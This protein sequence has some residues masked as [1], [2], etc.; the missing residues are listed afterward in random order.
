MPTYVAFLR[1]INLGA[2]RRFPKA[3]VLAATG[4]AGGEDVQAYLNTGNVLLTS[5][6]RSAAAVARDLER[7]YAEDRGF[8]VPTIVFTTAEVAAI[9][10]T[11]D[12]LV[13]ELGE[14]AQLNVT[15]Y[16]DPPPA[17]AARAVE[18]L[19]LPDR[20]VVRDRA[21][22]VFLHD[23]FHGSKLLG[24]KEFRA[25]GA[26]TARNVTVLREIARRWCR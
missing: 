3:D 11:A 7:A 15:L 22:Y 6:R 5:R 23:G 18:A 17:E 12:E 4:A 19:G 9:A 26:G 8:E 13:A 21:A 14:P 25:L 10:E 24:A 16:A 2:K 20:A 1:A